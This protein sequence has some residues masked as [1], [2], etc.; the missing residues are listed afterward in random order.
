M[1]VS[2]FGRRDVWRNGERREWK[3]AVV[4]VLLSQCN[5]LRNCGG[6][7]GSGKSQM[8][9]RDRKAEPIS[10][11]LQWMTMTVMKGWMT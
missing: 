3:Q 1:V 6:D 9:K 11:R 7:L 8:Q 4:F 5:R 10:R 2:L